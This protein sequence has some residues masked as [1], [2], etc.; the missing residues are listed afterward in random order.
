MTA[1]AAADNSVYV[2]VE[3]EAPIQSFL[4]GG[5]SVSF[6]TYIKYIYRHGHMFIINSRA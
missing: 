1:R 5:A 6:L 3:S 4:G 2:I